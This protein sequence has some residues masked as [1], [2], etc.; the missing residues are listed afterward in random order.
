MI[1]CKELDKSFETKSK[2]FEALRTNKSHIIEMKKAQV[3][4]SCEKETTIKARLLKPELLSGA[5]K[6]LL[7]DSEYHYIAVNSTKILD[8]HEDL[9]LDGLWSKSVKE[10]QGKN[11]LV[12]DH[13]LSVFNTVVKKEDI[14]MFT[15]VVPFAA[16]GKAY[17]GDTEVLVYKFLKSKVLM[18]AI[19]EWLESGDDIEA[20]VRMQYVKLDLA[21]D[22]EEEADKEAKRIFDKYYPIIANKEDF[23]EIKYFWIISEAKNVR[24]SSL[25]L[26]G[27][28]GATGALESK[29]IEPPEGTQESEAEKSLQ[30]NQ[31]TYYKSLF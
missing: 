16:I 11:Y 13:Q 19:S 28:N 30:Q 18:P 1:V 8:S 15:A 31:N 12:L 2:L 23:E 27:S 6:E 22:S 20:S 5:A 25:V 3:L 21:M 7:L 17:E 10:Q 26:A 29:N 4:K 9:H 24:E 14:E